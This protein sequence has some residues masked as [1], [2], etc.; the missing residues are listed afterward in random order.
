MA[1]FKVPYKKVTNKDEAYTRVCGHITPEYVAKFQVKVDIAYDEKNKRIDAK[2]NGF[3]L[4]LV[5][6]ENEC[7]VDLDMSFLLKPL[8][9]HIVSKIQ[10]QLER[11]I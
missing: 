9:P 5:F 4:S 8:K 6:G 1:D 7:V 2:G 3:H 11:H 10:D